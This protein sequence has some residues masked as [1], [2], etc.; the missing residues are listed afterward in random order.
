MQTG[1]PS[2]AQPSPVFSICFAGYLGTT[3]SAD[4]HTMVTWFIIKPPLQP[5]G[6]K[7]GLFSK[8]VLGHLDII[9]EKV[10]FEPSL[11]LYTKINERWIIY[12]NVARYNKVFGKRLRRLVDSRI[13]PLHP[14]CPHPNSQNLGLGYDMVKGNHRC[15]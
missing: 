6:G 13:M 8:M 7:N 3:G 1:A 5:N 15:R 14:K 2:P 4:P 9:W 10:S 12:P 11:S